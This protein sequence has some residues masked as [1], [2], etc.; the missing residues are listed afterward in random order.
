MKTLLIDTTKA[1]LHFQNGIV[2]QCD[3][4]KRANLTWESLPKGVPGANDTGRVY[5]WDYVDALRL[6]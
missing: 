5:P 2:L 6:A 3:D 1:G 4:P